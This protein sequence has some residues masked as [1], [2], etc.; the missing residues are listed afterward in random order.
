[1]L[2]AA[3]MIGTL[4]VKLSLEKIYPRYEDLSENLNTRTDRPGECKIWMGTKYCCILG[5]NFVHICR[6]Y[7]LK[8]TPYR[9]LRS[10]LHCLHIS[11]KTC[12]L[13]HPA[14]SPSPMNAPNTQPKLV[15]PH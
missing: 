11:S 13:L 6:C 12:S 9:K 5:N 14:P 8:P 7:S 15:I 10:E 1:M 2:S 3:V 4:R